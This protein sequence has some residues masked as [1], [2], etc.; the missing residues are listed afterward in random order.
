MKN[1]NNTYENNIKVCDLFIRRLEGFMRFV[2]PIVNEK[3]AC[4]ENIS[5]LKEKLA[6]EEKA[7]LQIDNLTIKIKG[8]AIDKPQVF[9]IVNETCSQWDKS[10]ADII[11]ENKKSIEAAKNSLRRFISKEL[12]VSSQ[13]IEE[14]EKLYCSYKEQNPQIEKKF[15]ADLDKHL[16]I[17]KSKGL[18]IGFL[19]LN[20]LKE[21]L[22]PVN[23]EGTSSAITEYKRQTVKSAEQAEDTAENIPVV[24]EVNADITAEKQELL[25]IIQKESEDSSKL[26]NQI[27]KNNINVIISSA[28][29]KLFNSRKKVYLSFAKVIH[30][31]KHTSDIIKAR[32]HEAFQILTELISKTKDELEAIKSQKDFKKETHATEKKEKKNAEVLQKAILTLQKIIEE[33][34][35]DNL[36]AE[37]KIKLEN[38]LKDILKA[39]DK[40]QAIII[41]LAETIAKKKKERLAAIKIQ[42]VLRK[43]ISID[44]TEKRR[45]AVIKI[46]NALR[47]K[48]AVKDLQVVASSGTLA[49]EEI[50]VESA[51]AIAPDQSPSENISSAAPS[52]VLSRGS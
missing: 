41:K 24:T 19:F 30:P 37:K 48:L 47:K 22:T 51:N 15:L 31:D 33:A 39:T 2:A 3:S 4:I 11:T 13:C 20:Y 23:T 45:L 52:N 34:E 27:E 36:P 9:N 17:I 16:H 28:F 5:K 25:S 8:F 29:L 10:I 14:Y 46:Q 26:L 49:A 35:D 32:A 42:T 44:P 1:N 18:Y 50:R 40:M 12:E 38:G 7:K 6:E 21:N 43:K